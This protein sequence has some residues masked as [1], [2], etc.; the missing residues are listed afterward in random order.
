MQDRRS[1]VIAK[2]IAEGMTGSFDNV[3]SLSD[4]A[5]PYPR[6][7]YRRDEWSEQRIFTFINRAIKQGATLNT[8]KY[9]GFLKDAVVNASMAAKAK[10]QTN[11]TEVAG[12]G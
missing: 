10:A 9:I 4:Y 11:T 7:S 12:G 6:K 1:A 5:P 3:K 2:T 8:N